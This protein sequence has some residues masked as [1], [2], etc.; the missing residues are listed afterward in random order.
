MVRTESEVSAVGYCPL[1][2]CPN[3]FCVW[4]KGIW[5]YA[6]ADLQP[7]QKRARLLWGYPI[8]KAC[9]ELKYMYESSPAVSWGEL[10]HL[11]K[12]PFSSH[13]GYMSTSFFVLVQTLHS[14]NQLACLQ[15]SWQPPGAHQQL[16]AALPKCKLAQAVL[17]A[18]LAQQPQATELSSHEPPS[19]DSIW[20][21][22]SVL[23][24]WLWCE[25]YQFQSPPNISV[26]VNGGTCLLACSL[27][28]NG[29][30]CRLCEVPFPCNNFEIY[31]LF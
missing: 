7:G 27:I 24:P 25:V 29:T 8:D 31:K 11:G 4:Y 18:A 12:A 28:I 19:K 16:H 5:A 1:F 9:E 14:S 22:S 17:F 10:P 23:N 3:T 2:R 20:M 21:S 30:D 6:S 15:V 13:F 26:N